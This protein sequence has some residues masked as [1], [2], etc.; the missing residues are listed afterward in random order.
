MPCRWRWNAAF[1]DKPQFWSDC[2]NK[3]YT[4]ESDV[5][6]WSCYHPSWGRH[7]ARTRPAPG[8]HDYVTPGATGYFN[9]FGAAAG[10]AG[11]GYYSYDLR[12]WHI[13]VI[14]TLAQTN[15]GP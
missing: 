10:P 15:P 13:V 5:D 12:Q 14:S 9:Y 4:F 11:Q 2:E 8:N 6:F 3:T 7:K 1:D